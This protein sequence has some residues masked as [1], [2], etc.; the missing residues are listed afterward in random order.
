MTP[1]NTHRSVCTAV[2]ER[3]AQT[4]ETD[5]LSL[6]ALDSAVNTDALNEL[7]TPKPTG[8]QRSG[9]VTVTFTYADCLVVVHGPNTVY[10]R[11]VD[12]M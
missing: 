8:K 10:V 1:H 5:V 11:C 3:V 9:S 4:K 2:L 6:P 12:S 7:Y